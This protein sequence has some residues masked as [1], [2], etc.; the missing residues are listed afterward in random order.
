MA[1]AAE[2][3]TPV[4]VIEYTPN[5][6]DIIKRTSGG[7]F[8]HIEIRSLANPFQSDLVEVLTDLVE[9]VDGNTSAAVDSPALESTDVAIVPPASSRRATRGAVANGEVADYCPISLQFYTRKY[10]THSAAFDP[11]QMFEELGVFPCGCQEINCSTNNKF[12]RCFYCKTP[13]HSYCTESGLE[14]CCRNCFIKRH[15]DVKV[16]VDG[17]KKSKVFI[18]NLQIVGR[19]I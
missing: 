2:P 14:A 18:T 10:V 12:P 11:E 19:R 1:N 8:K 9:E 5:G 17:Q 7:A 13:M 4:P 16:L 3:A 6:V 15:N